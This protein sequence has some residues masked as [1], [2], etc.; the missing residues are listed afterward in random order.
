MTL[1]AVGLIGGFQVVT[2][3]QYCGGA[4]CHEG[5]TVNSDDGAKET[6]EDIA[7]LLPYGKR[8]KAEE[9]L[10]DRQASPTMHPHPTRGA[11]LP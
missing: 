2:Y 8:E 3:G 10:E 9:E 11:G 4:G 5:R 1:V 7:R 6:G